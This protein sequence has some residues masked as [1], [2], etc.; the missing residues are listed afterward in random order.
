MHAT[1]ANTEIIGGF[2]SVIH[3]CLTRVDKQNSPEYL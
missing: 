1:K 3:S 2:P